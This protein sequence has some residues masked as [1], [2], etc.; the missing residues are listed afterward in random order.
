MG[1]T[2][3]A[4][5]GGGGG[6]GRVGVGGGG[7][8]GGGLGY[9]GLSGCL[10]MGHIIPSA[11]Q[12]PVI[13]VV[14]SILHAT[15]ANGSTNLFIYSPSRNSHQVRM[16][17]APLVASHGLQECARHALYMKSLAP[18]SNLYS[19]S[20]SPLQITQVTHS[21]E[22]SAGASIIAGVRTSGTRKSSTSTPCGR[23]DNC[24]GVGHALNSLCRPG[25]SSHM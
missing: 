14:A 13:A 12:L 3:E 9:A 18:Q 16:I 19:W 17:P 8:G 10:I 20:C 1:A 4:M 25:S 11:Y 15:A 5:F 23:T 24:C 7:G 2:L 6:C 22:Y 21:H